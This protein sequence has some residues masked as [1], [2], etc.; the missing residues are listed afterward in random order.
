[1]AAPPS[2][3]SSNKVK[4]IKAANA[5]IAK[6]TISQRSKVP[7]L[8]K[9]PVFSKKGILLNHL[10]MQRTASTGNFCPILK[11]VFSKNHEKQFISF[12]SL[13][14]LFTPALKREKKIRG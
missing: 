2:T 6:A 4:Q 14:F 3:L 10:G 1:M 11:I 9:L 13:A 8:K 5:P 7:Y 12:H